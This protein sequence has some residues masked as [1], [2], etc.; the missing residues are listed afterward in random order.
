MGRYYSYL[1]P[2][3]PS[4]MAELSQR[5]V[6][7]D[8]MGHPESLRIL[9]YW[10][11]TECPILLVKTCYDLIATVLAPGGPILSYLMPR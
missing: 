2:Y 5:E 11:A 8:E 6:I 4:K 9:G 1:L 10:V 3:Y 7:T